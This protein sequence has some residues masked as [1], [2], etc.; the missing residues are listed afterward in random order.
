M[1]KGNYVWEEPP[2]HFRG[3]LEKM[4]LWKE[5]QLLREELADAQARATE[6]INLSAK[7]AIS[8]DFMKLELILSGALK[9]PG[10]A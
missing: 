4:G 7:Q 3:D 9:M 8:S 6:Y 2:T 5:I 10:N 1:T